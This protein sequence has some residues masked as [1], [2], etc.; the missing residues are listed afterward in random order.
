M[1]PIALIWNAY[2]NYLAN[3]SALLCD[4]VYYGIG[5]S[6]GNGAPVLLVPGFLLGDSLLAPM[7][8]WLE[9]I[10]YHSYLSGIDWN[11]G[12]P[13]QT[14]EQLAERLD[15]IA[16]DN[17]ARVAIVGH[18]LG[19]MFARRLAAMRPDVVRHVITLGTPT[20]IERQVIRA[21]VQPALLALQSLWGIFGDA[22]YGCGTEECSCGIRNVLSDP[23]TVD[24]A[25]SVIFTRDDDVVDWRACVEPGSRNYEVS[26]K[27][28]S[29]IV[30][31]EVYRLI[32]AILAEQHAAV[33]RDRLPTVDRGEKTS[34]RVA[35][36]T[37]GEDGRRRGPRF[38][39]AILSRI[40]TV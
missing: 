19:G 7:A 8:R 20:G 26:G 9:V 1:D 35:S 18:S 31:P 37:L 21:D 15:R 11:I 24:C 2:L 38:V 14:F 12:C 28:C 17:A 39:E 33:S 34:R 4:P 40:T 23:H 22:P 10:G 16:R 27:H 13:R 3:L 5:V 36:Y 30:N 29:L 6:R 32:A 25:T